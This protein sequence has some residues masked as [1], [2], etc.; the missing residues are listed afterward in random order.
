MFP[1]SEQRD[2][3]V[4]WAEIESGVE[5]SAAVGAPAAKLQNGRNCR[6]AEHAPPSLIP[7]WMGHPHRPPP[8]ATRPPP[9]SSCLGPARVLAPTTSAVQQAR[10]SSWKSLIG[11][12]DPE[13]R[14]RLSLF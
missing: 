11:W 5:S 7:P 8:P 2:G 14:R 9:I 10:L 12:P 13:T 3:K 6:T 1:R 4:G